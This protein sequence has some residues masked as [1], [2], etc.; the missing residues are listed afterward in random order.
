MDSVKKTYKKIIKDLKVF[1]KNLNYVLNKSNDLCFVLFFDILW[2][3]LRFGVTSNEY[4]IF[5]FYNINGDKRNTFISRRRYNYLNRKLVNKKVVNIINSKEKF[6]SRFKNYLKRDISNIN[7]MSFKQIEDFILDNKIVIGRSNSSSYISSYK[8]YNLKDYRSSAFLAD[9]IKKSKNYLIEKKFIQNKELN[10]INSLVFVN[11]VSV[12]DK[13][14][15]IVSASIKYKDNKDIIS[16]YVDLDNKCIKGHLKNEEGK[17]VDN[18][19]DGFEIPKFNSII[20]IV[21]LLSEELKEIKQVEWSFVIGSKSIYLVDANIWDD[22]VFSQIPE[23]LND[24][25]GLMEYYKK[26]FL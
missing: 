26:F 13:K 21:N 24:N 9:D 18:K 6:N 20:E 16:G 11:I 8:E 25:V 15:D 1:N 2:C 19:F 23:Y 4:R 10:K 7:E 3:K 14:P 17:N 22:Y 5:E 12:Y